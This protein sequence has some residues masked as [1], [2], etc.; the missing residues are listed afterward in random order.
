MSTDLIDKI[1][2]IEHKIGRDERGRSPDTVR[3]SLRRLRDDVA[4]I[5]ENPTSLAPAGEEPGIWE[6]IFA[7][8]DTA[9]SDSPA[10][11]EDDVEA[12]RADIWMEERRRSLRRPQNA[13]V[14]RQDLYYVRAQGGREELIILEEL[15]REPPPFMTPDL[16]RLLAVAIADIN[17]RLSSQPPGPIRTGARLNRADGPPVGPSAQAPP[18]TAAELPAMVRRVR[19]M[20]GFF[21]LTFVVDGYEHAAGRRFWDAARGL[22]GRRDTYWLLGQGAAAGDEP[23]YLDMTEAA[24]R[25]QGA[26]LLADVLF[27]AAGDA[28]E[29]AARLAKWR[30][31]AWAVIVA[32]PEEPAEIDAGL[33][34]LRFVWRDD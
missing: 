4:T 30:R 2:R 16:E 24:D 31:A 12:L 33:P 22:L 19:E 17:R 6:R 28:D 3:R 27:V 11:I 1:D 10:T 15:R 8:I 14:L 7:D 26:A 5:Q 21:P 29:L 13:D 18:L 9:H 32:A 34:H 23:G 20:V 25:E